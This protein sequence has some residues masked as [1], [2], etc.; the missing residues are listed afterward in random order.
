MRV[1]SDASAS[2]VTRCAVQYGA[3]RHTLIHFFK[4]NGAQLPPSV[5]IL[6]RRHSDLIRWA[7]RDGEDRLI[8]A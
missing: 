5:V 8:S 2:D 6:F 1:L 3:F 4:P 7:A